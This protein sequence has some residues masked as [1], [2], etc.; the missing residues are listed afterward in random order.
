MIAA[1]TSTIFP[2]NLS[3]NGTLRN[4][5]SP[6]ERLQQTLQTIESLKLF[7]FD[8]IFLFDNSGDKWESSI[9]SNFAEINLVKVDTYQF[10]NKGINEVLLLLQNLK[11]MPE[12]VPILKISGRYRLLWD[13]KPE[14]DGYDLAVRYF[15]TTAGRFTM[16]TSC[17]LIK[18][19]NTYERLLKASLEEHYAEHAR[20]QN[21]QALTR[22]VRN[23]L[24]KKGTNFSDPPLPIEFA[25]AS[26]VRLCNLKYKSIQKNICEG[27][28]GANPDTVHLH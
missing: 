8:Q 10:A 5:L 22:F 1:I 28:A 16:H 18:N 26:A 9:D 15:K 19:K 13:I 14:L 20:V 12:N 24:L 27:I 4:V 6:A 21:K 3:S 11:F 25:F 7:G 23:N 2:E 17:Y